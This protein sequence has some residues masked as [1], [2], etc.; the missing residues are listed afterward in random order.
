MEPVTPIYNKLQ[1][2][3]IK[4]ARK[5]L[6]EADRETCKKEMLFSQPPPYPSVEKQFPILKGKVEVMGEAEVKGQVEI[7]PAVK[8][9]SRE[10][11][12][13][14]KSICP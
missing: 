4:Q 8:T 11:K 12:K 9:E 6:K 14:V 2:R 13:K 10:R 5:I 7:G 3:S 1:R